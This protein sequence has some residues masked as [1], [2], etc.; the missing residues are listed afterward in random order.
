MIIWVNG[1][2][3]SGK[4]TLVD[5][6]HRRWP[7]ALVYDPEQIG[8]VLRGIVDVPTGNFQDLRLWRRQVVSMAVGLLEEYERP[9]LAPMTLA[10]PQYV[11]EIFGA[12]EEAGVAV[13]HFFLKV[14]AEVLARR[15]DARSV[16]PRDPERDEAVR[17]W[18]K[19]RIAQCVAAAD[20]LPADTIF[21]DGERPC[22]E[23]ADEVLTRVGASV[24]S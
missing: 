13:H 14:P 10:D 24:N 18:C 7:A 12:L 4:T 6:L 20:T 3:G 1:A 5:E 2:F 21:L 22:R 16:V 11:A 23:L 17:Q 19:A 9:I 8:Y 15:I